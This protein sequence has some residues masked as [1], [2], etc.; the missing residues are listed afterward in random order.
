MPDNKETQLSLQKTQQTLIIADI[1]AGLATGFI[2]FWTSLSL[3]YPPIF[4]AIGAAIAWT[5]ARGRG[6]SNY[7][8]MIA[9]IF[10]VTALIGMGVGVGSSFGSGAPIV[11]P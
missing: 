5:V 9:M 11:G 1:F 8:M 4:G 2:A 10:F 3:V 7:A 6:D